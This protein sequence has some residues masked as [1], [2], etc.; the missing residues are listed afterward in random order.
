MVGQVGLKP[1]SR[2]MSPAQQLKREQSV[3][4]CFSRADASCHGISNTWFECDSRVRVLRGQPCS[5]ASLPASLASARFLPSPVGSDKMRNLLA[6]YP[7]WFEPD[8]V[9][10]LVGA[11]DKAWETVQATGV[12]YAEAKAEAVRTI[13][14]KQIIEASSKPPARR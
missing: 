3:A 8:E 10:I 6:E 1:R 11:F 5:R 9:Q 12:V 13:L 14:A 2:L 7:A 4:S